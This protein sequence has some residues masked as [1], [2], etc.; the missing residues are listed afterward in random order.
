[1]RHEPELPGL[2]VEVRVGQ[3]WPAYRQPRCRGYLREM[4]S[5]DRGSRHLLDG[6]VPLYSK[7]FPCSWGESRLNFVPDYGSH[8]RLQLLGT[9]HLYHAVLS[10][11]GCTLVMPPFRTQSY[12]FSGLSGLRS[13][14]FFGT[15]IRCRLRN[16]RRRCPPLLSRRCNTS[17]TLSETSQCTLGPQLYEPGEQS[18]TFFIS[19]QYRDK[20]LAG[21]GGGGGEG[22]P[23]ASLELPMTLGLSVN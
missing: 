19:S 17:R 20:P 8:R 22:V 21:G 14:S 1:M 10:R 13:E 4:V 2:W 3:R 9:G 7:Y 23:V 11:S 12:T 5:I 6:A 15:S 18:P 16:H